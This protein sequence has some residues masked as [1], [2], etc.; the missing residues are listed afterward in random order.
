MHKWVS[1]AAVQAAASWCLSYLKLFDKEASF[2]I[3]DRFVVQQARL[4]VTNICSH[5][6]TRQI[7]KYTYK[8]LLMQ[9]APL[10]F[11]NLV[12]R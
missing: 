11:S 7:K 3:D 6:N 5:K 12:H 8:V 1:G 10:T 9:W 4:D 2:C